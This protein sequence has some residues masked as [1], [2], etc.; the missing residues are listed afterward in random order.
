LKFDKLYAEL[1]CDGYHVNP[2]Y[3]RDIIKRKGVSR[4]VGITDCSMIAGSN[5][6][7]FRVEG[8]EG[9]VSD[10][11]Q[12]LQVLGKE[13]TLFSSNLTMVRGFTNLLNWLTRDMEGIWNKRHEGRELEE[14]VSAAAQIFASNPCELTGLTG[15]GYGRIVEGAKADLCV[16]DIRQE[17]GRYQAEV[18]KT[19]VEG[20][21][22]Y[23]KG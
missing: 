7:E 13:N 22:V 10:D 9:K 12:Y 1:I 21:V 19:I 3:I 15:Q 20:E 8:I 6:T 17:E 23:A 14:A 18:E 11:G 2:A 4:I 16:L 5:L